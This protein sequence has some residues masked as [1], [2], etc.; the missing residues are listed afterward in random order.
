MVARALLLA[1]ADTT[2]FYI[3]GAKQAGALAAKLGPE[4]NSAAL[5]ER[6]AVSDGTTLA[7]SVTPT[8]AASLS[9]SRGPRKPTNATA[10]ADLP[11]A[12]LNLVALV[13][14]VHIACLRGA[15]EPL[16]AAL[17]ELEGLREL[18]IVERSV[19]VPQRVL[20]W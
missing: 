18:T 20:R 16:E 9:A 2:V 13:A 14:D 1:C 17:G 8:F 5:G 4:K 7:D 3:G 12:T 19:L 11:H 10:L 15:L 6:V